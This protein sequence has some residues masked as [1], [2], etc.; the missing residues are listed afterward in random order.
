METLAIEVSVAYD[1]KIDV[2]QLI[3]MIS[4]ALTDF[5][6]AYPEARIVRMEAEEV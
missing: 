3:N 1:G 2:L 6:A 5:E 4:D